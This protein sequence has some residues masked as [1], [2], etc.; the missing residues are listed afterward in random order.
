MVPL[1]Q[2]MLFKT[3]ETAP[4]H[5]PATRSNSL[6]KNVERPKTNA[7]GDSV[8]GMT[9]ILQGHKWWSVIELSNYLGVVPATVRSNLARYRKRFGIVDRIGTDGRHQI[10]YYRIMQNEF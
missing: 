4:T 2:Q 7:F 1:L 5:P 6:I 10:K 9:K 3:P 8:I